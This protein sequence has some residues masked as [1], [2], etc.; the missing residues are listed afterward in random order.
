MNLAQVETIEDAKKY[1]LERGTVTR[2][3]LHTLCLQFDATK[4]LLAFVREHKI[5]LTGRPGR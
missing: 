4:E 1:L 5:E 3:V 2:E